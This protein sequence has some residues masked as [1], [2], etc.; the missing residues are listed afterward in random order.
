[1]YLNYDGAKLSV[2]SVECKLFMLHTCKT[3][4][5]NKCPCSILLIYF[6]K[7][8]V[9]NNSVESRDVENHI[10]NGMYRFYL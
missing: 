4:I 5:I 2:E 10:K 1:M 3:E 9:A 7:Y 6:I 8:F